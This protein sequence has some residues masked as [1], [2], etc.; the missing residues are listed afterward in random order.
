[1][2]KTDKQTSDNI[3]E[4]ASKSLERRRL[5]VSG[6]KKS[7]GSCLVANVEEFKHILLKYCLRKQR[8]GGN[9]ALAAFAVLEHEAL[10]KEFGHLAA[11]QLANMVQSIVLKQIRDADRLCN[12]S[13]AEFLLLLPDCD[14]NGLSRAVERISQAVAS[15]KTQ[16]HKHSL[17][18]SLSIEYVAGDGGNID[19]QALLNDIG[20]E[21]AADGKLCR[22]NVGVGIAHLSSD[23]SS[24]LTRYDGI[25]AVN[26]TFLTENIKLREF[27]ALDTWLHDKNV[28]LSI[29]ETKGEDLANIS[30][31]FSAR[32]RI[33]QSIDHPGLLPIDD[34][35]VSENGSLAFTCDAPEYEKLKPRLEGLDFKPDDIYSFIMQILHI[36]IYLQTVIPPVVPSKIGSESFYADDDKQLIL[37]N[38]Y[39]TY[40]LPSIFSDYSAKEDAQGNKTSCFIEAFTGLLSELA[41]WEKQLLKANDKPLLTAL[42]SELKQTPASK[43]LNTLYKVRSRL[44][45]ILT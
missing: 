26:E 23:L 42:L 31:T 4:A 6:G 37:G 45:E 29:I 12:L 28:Q 15:G 18:A 10:L 22:Q 1:M 7:D 5:P 16:Y 25:A 11:N 35:Y 39:L 36:L 33:L 44:Q 34:Y 30:S 24:W 40:L 21:I 9:F 3:S 43:S 20:Y 8:D 17:H 41:E 13:S 19:A 27:L 14:A 38:C 2:G 32:A